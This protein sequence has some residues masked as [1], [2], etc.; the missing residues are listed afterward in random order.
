MSHETETNEAA[1]Q[2]TH[3]ETTIT[4][5]TQTHEEISHEPTLF[6]EPVLTVGS[7][8]ITNSLLTSWVVVVII[9]LFS[10]ALRKKIAKIPRGIQNAFEIVV[11]GAMNMADSVTGDR[12]KTE[13]IFPFVFAIL[14]LFC[15]IIGSA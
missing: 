9:V 8:Q 10:L 2:T 12:K 6:A 1:Q 3:E 11:E 13:R 14:F 4:A 15:L 5:E 7:F